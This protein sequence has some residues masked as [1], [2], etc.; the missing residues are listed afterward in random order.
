MTRA[1]G[2]EFRAEELADCQGE[3]NAL[4]Y[5]PSMETSQVGAAERM[6]EMRDR[7]RELGLRELRLAV[8]DPRRAA[9]RAR[10]AAQVA[11]LKPDDESEALRFAEAASEF[12]AG[13]ANDI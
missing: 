1:R 13:E 8:P 2:R 5:F 4:Q 11:R 6:R 10:V 7:R 12:D 3:R 9:V